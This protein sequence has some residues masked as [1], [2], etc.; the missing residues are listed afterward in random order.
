MEICE[1]SLYKNYESWLSLRKKEVTYL[2]KTAF[3]NHF[4]ISI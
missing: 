1:P 2:S 3:S 4:I